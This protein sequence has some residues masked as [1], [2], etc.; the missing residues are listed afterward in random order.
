MDKQRVL[1]LLCALQKA[2]VSGFGNALSH[3]IKDDA[4][5]G[6]NR[7]PVQTPGSLVASIAGRE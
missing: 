2:L 3:A 5:G 4:V 6:K 1:S 7:E